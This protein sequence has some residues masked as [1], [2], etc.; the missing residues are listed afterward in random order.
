MTN[1]L[2]AEPASVF[3]ALGCATRLDLIGRLNT[4]KDYSIAELTAGLELTRQAVTKHL[5]VLYC[6]GI[7]QRRRVGRESRFAIQPDSIAEAS[8]YLAAVSSQ[9]D[10]SIHRLRS[11]LEK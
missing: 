9:W 1:S 11:H 8:R 6:A 4:G 7:V 2:N 3:A 10:E 5:N